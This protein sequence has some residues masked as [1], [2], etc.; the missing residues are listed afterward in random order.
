[1][2]AP[3]LAAQFGLFLDDDRADALFRQTQGRLHARN[4][5]AYN[6]NSFF[7]YSLMS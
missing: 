6:D 2:P 1:V 4:A 5:A 3:E 7:H